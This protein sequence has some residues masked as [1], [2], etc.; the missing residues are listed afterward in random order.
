MDDT[1]EAVAR[2]LTERPELE[3]TLRDLLTTDARGAWEHDDVELDS[4]AFGELVSR[5]FVESVEDGYRFADRQAVKVVLETD[6]PTTLV[7]NSS[8]DDTPRTTG[9]FGIIRET[10]L[11]AF[12]LV[13]GALALVALVRTVLVW[14]DVVRGDDIVLAGND[15]YLYRYW[16]EQLVTSDLGVF[17]LNRLEVIS[18][19]IPRHDTLYIVVIW[20]VGSLLGGD[21]AAVGVGLAWLPVVAGVLSA[22]LVYALTVRLT[23][24]RRVGLATVALLAVTPTHAF[25]TALGFGDHHA[26]DYIWVALTAYVVVSLADAAHRRDG[27]TPSLGEGVAIVALAVGIWAQ[28]LSWRGGPL[29][30]IPVGIYVTVQV[31]VAVRDDQSPTSAVSPVLLGI[32]VGASLTAVTHLGLGWA[33]PYRAFAPTLLA[34]GTVAVVGFATLARRLGTSARA[35]VLVEV[36]AGFGSLAVALAVVPEFD[37]AFDEL[38]AYFVRTG[39]SGIAETY[40]LFSGELGSVLGPIFLFGFVFFLAA[41]YAA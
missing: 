33:P 32:G 2:L 30:S 26:F 22:A 39:Q 4:G 11:R 37:T 20:W 6:D 1:R 24:D 35:L 15:A 28:A 12:L 23:D 25:R 14:P 21:Y 10:D 36:V 41:P 38:L 29:L 3:T 5:S 17:D 19:R 13:V 40:S 18:R 9:V 7:D 31:L 16:G 27:I 34:V 8:A